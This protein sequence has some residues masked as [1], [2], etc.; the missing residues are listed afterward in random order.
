VE[1]SFREALYRQIG[2][3]I[4]IE[5]TGIQNSKSEFGMNHLCRM[6]ADHSPW[7]TEKEKEAEAFLKE[8]KRK[9]LLNFVE[10]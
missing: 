9:I 7:M 10:L 5:K 1:S 4:M 6:K 3:A 2:E 8:K